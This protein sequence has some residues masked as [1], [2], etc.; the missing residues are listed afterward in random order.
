MIILVPYNFA[1]RGW[2]FCNGQ[3][4]A[5]S[6]NTALFSLLGTTYG[7]NGQTTFA[8]PDLRGRVPNSSGQGPGLRNYDLGQSSGTESVTM[9]VNQL[10]SHSH[11]ITL[12]TLKATANVKNAAGNRQSPVG[13][14]PAIEAAGVTATYSSAAPDAA[15]ALGAVS[16]S[17]AP[18]AAP[19]GGGQPFD[20]L[21]PYLTLNYCIALSGIFPSRN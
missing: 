6:Q 13:N 16:L 5:I 17:G 20:I 21:Q 19:I 2:A 1:P 8:L 14:V 3:I 7:G 4:L 9:T 10:P 11:L 18:L 12:D 15:M